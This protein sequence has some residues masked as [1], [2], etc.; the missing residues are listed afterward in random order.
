MRIYCQLHTYIIKE[1]VGGAQKGR[2]RDVGNSYIQ[3]RS[4]LA[5]TCI[6]TIW[7]QKHATRTAAEEEKEGKAYRGSIV[8][9][10]TFERART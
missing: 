3:N 4:M 8:G 5:P 6:K 7:K 1:V 10:D 9:F 2:G